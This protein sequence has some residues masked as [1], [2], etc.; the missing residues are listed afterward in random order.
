MFLQARTKQLL[1]F[2][3]YWHSSIKNIKA[4]SDTRIGIWYNVCFFFQMKVKS[5]DSFSAD[6]SLLTLRFCGSWFC[7]RKHRNCRSLPAWLNASVGIYILCLAVCSVTNQCCTE[8]MEPIEYVLAQ[9]FLLIILRRVGKN[10]D[11]S[12]IESTLL[13]NLVP[14]CRLT[15]KFST[16]CHPLQFMSF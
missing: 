3:V 5:C 7:G 2:V 15:E 11:I 12:K 8:M 6:I 1:A 16:A 9:R 10:L 13:C 4:E 14:K